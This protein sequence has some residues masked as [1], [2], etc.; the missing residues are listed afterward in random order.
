MS[1][2]FDTHALIWFVENSP[3]LSDAARTAVADSSEEV[4]CSVASNWE[5]ALKLSLGKL[6]MSIVLEGPFERLLEDSGFI[7]IPVEYPPRRASCL[8]ALASPGPFR[9]PVSLTSTRRYSQ[10]CTTFNSGNH[11]LK[12]PLRVRR[13]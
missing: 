1:L 9:S 7:L 13:P 4:F 12:S 5:M 8:A 6:K 2:L 3:E 10:G 11:F